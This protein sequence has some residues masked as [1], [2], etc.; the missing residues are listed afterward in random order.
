MKNPPAHTLH[1]GGEFFGEPEM[2]DE[3]ESADPGITV[4]EGRAR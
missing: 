3:D 1:T 4:G 2:S